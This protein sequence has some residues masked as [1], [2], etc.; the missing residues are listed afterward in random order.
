[1]EALLTSQREVEERTVHPVRQF[2]DLFTRVSTANP[3]PGAYAMR[4][5]LDHPVPCW[6][7]QH[8]TAVFRFSVRLMTPVP[9]GRHA[10][11]LQPVFQVACRC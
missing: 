9:V 6:Q 5:V 1:M 2:Y 7:A 4:L 3:D 8:V 10:R 11:P